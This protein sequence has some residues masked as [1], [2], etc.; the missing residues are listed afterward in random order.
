MDFQFQ[1]EIEIPS[2]KETD[3]Y[4]YLLYSHNYTRTVDKLTWYIPN[5][6]EELQNKLLKAMERKNFEEKPLTLEERR[7]IIVL[8]NEKFVSI[9][10]IIPQ[11]YPISFN[12][13][14]YVDALNYTAR[15]QTFE[16]LLDY[17][18]LVGGLSFLRDSHEPDKPLSW[19]RKERET[20][21]VILL[22]SFANTSQNT[23]GFV[24][25]HMTNILANEK[26]FKLLKCSGMDTSQTFRINVGSYFGYKTVTQTFIRRVGRGEDIDKLNTSIKHINN[27]CDTKNGTIDA[28]FIEVIEHNTVKFYKRLNFNRPKSDNINN[29]VVEKVD[30]ETNTDRETLVFSA[31][32]QNVFI[33][34][35]PENER[36]STKMYK[37]FGTNTE[38]LKPNLN[39]TNIE[40]VVIKKE[41]PEYN[42]SEETMERI[43]RNVQVDHAY[44]DKSHIKS[45][46]I[47]QVKSVPSIDDVKNEFLELPECLDTSHEVEYY[48]QEIARLKAQVKRLER[49]Q[50]DST[51]LMK[52]FSPVIKLSNLLNE[53][54]VLQPKVVMLHRP[55]IKKK[56]KA[57]NDLNT[58]VNCSNIESVLIKKEEPEDDPLEN[59]DENMI[60]S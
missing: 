30:K 29:K 15:S 43:V 18:L 60:T 16:D 9:F 14:R 38:D 36:Y 39:C 50:D 55:S 33:K 56:R 12:V 2:P 35:E 44:Y 8:G 1:S 32:Q 40:N 21:F 41:E 59:N 54:K 7:V 52:M 6:K 11:N 13:C 34:C 51:K 42:D 4:K 47:E 5:K 22:A 19:L 49:Q 57:N 31:D 24:K 58:F 26:L 23:L 46:M 27:C 10:A 53:R 28:E 45:L 20:Y 48:I 17:P 25:L 37:D 3:Y